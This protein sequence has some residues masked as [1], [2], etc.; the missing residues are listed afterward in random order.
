MFSV[1]PATAIFTS[2]RRIER[3][4]IEIAAIDEQ[5]ARSTV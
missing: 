1:P 3:E 5:Q 4:A 2:P